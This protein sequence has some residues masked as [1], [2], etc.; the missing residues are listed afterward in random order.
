MKRL[1]VI[2][3]FFATALTIFVIG[4]LLYNYKCRKV[5]IS[6]IGKEVYFTNKRP[7]SAKTCVPAAYTSYGDVIL[8]SFRLKGKS[9]QKPYFI[10]KTS[11]TNS[12]LIVSKKWCSDFGFEQHTLV[13]K[14]RACQ[15]SK[16]PNRRFR[17]ALCCKKNNK[18]E[19]YIIESTYPM[20]MTQFAAECSKHA[21]YAVNL[22]MGTYG[23]GRV[24]G[25]V[26]S[27]WTIFWKNKQTNWIYT[28]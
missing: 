27:W 9:H 6:S 11:L 26:C 22:D 24:N 28:N 14:G 4:I 17:R 1:L 12:G 19:Y 13:N 3:T 8:G 18:S 21:Y 2:I 7:D 16:D 20:T 25:K 15:F 5:I 10:H 23:Y